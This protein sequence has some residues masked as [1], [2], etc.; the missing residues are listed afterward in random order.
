LDASSVGGMIVSTFLWTPFGCS[1]TP[2]RGSASQVAAISAV[3]SSVSR[4]LDAERSRPT[5]AGATVL[6][7]GTAF[8]TSG[9]RDHL[10]PCAA[11][12]AGSA[13]GSASVFFDLGLGGG[14][15]VLGLVAAANGIPAAS[16]T[17]A[18]LAAAG[19]VLLASRPIPRAPVPASS[20]AG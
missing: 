3:A 15:V 7:T 19:A 16:L 20:D 12:P 5:P 6:A 14:P 13:A 4:E 17:A 1:I 10:Q 8:L 18:G 9:V 11:V 2:A